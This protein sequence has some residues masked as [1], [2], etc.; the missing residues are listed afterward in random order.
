MAFEPLS[1]ELHI[2]A[3]VAEDD[4]RVGILDIE[5]P[6]E[7][8]HSPRTRD[9]VEGV[10]HLLGADEVIRE[11]EHLRILEIALSELLYLVGYRGR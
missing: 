4:R 3:G 5:N 9:H 2:I 6:H 7:V 8:G 10:L 1:H 11:R